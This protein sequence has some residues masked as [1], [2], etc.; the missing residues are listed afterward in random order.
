MSGADHTEAYG[1]IIKRL[2]LLIYQMQAMQ[3]EIPNLAIEHIPFLSQL[4]FCLPFDALPR[5]I[6]RLGKPVKPLDKE[7]SPLARRNGVLVGHHSPDISFGGMPERSECPPPDLQYLMRICNTV[8][9]VT[10][11]IN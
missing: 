8:S 10:K 9:G 1:S 3:P 11:T 4:L 7:I 5:L 2:L 6:D